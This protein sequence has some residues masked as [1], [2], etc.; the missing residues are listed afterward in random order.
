ME[1]PHRSLSCP[2]RAQPPKLRVRPCVSQ[3]DGPSELLKSWTLLVEPPS[4]LGKLG[5][6]GAHTEHQDP[7][8]RHPIHEPCP[9][10]CTPQARTGHH[11]A[12]TIRTSRIHHITNPVIASSLHH[13]L[14]PR[15][16][17]PPPA[18]DTNNHR[19]C[20][21]ILLPLHDSLLF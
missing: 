18:K 3:S 12:R 6:Q 5:A 15:S 11:L 19:W 14:A 1:G 17:A 20:R 8:H 21:T 13:H 10:S 9:R 7:G 16:K 2:V 4:T